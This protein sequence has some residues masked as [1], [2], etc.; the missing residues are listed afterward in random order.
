M[1]E[2]VFECFKC[3]LLEVFFHGF[4]EFWVI[5]WEIFVIMFP[6]FKGFWWLIM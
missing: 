4:E 5:H 6:L 3:G 2:G 1:F